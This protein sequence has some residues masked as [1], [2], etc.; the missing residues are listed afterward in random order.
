MPRSSLSSSSSTV[1]LGRLRASLSKYGGAAIATEKKPLLIGHCALRAILCFNRGDC[2]DTALLSM[3]NAALTCSTERAS[4]SSCTCCG[5][6]PS[7]SAAARPIAASRRASARPSTSTA[8]RL[9]CANA[10]GAGAAHAYSLDKAMKMYARIR[11]FDQV[12]AMLR[13]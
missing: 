4:P 2:F 1:A 6:T 8:R 13:E 10:A 9:S 3:G 12:A 5:A 11:T 7:S